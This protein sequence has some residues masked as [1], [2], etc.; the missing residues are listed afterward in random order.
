M[1][2][3][4]SLKIQMNTW[5]S[6][7]ISLVMHAVFFISAAHF[8]MSQPFESEIFNQS[9][10]E[11]ISVMLISDSSHVL[12]EKIKKV[13][14]EL[15]SVQTKMSS[16]SLAIKDETE[17]T[18][19]SQQISSSDIQTVKAGTNTKETRPNQSARPDYSFNPTPNYPALLREQGVSGEVMLLVWVSSDG[20]PIEIKL[21]RS[22][23]YRLMDDAALRAV[24]Q[25]RFIPAKH[26][27][28]NLASWVEIPIKFTI[29]G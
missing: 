13:M 6:F 3:S 5:I 4:I 22:S 10:K 21:T 19:A 24:R 11:P 28:V 20:T 15:V 26:G 29:N 8:T 25:W 17:P 14:P 23:G 12:G 2:S 1:T 7:V 16:S 27:E 9:A 18:T